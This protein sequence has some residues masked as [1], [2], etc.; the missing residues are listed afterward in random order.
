MQ[1]IADFV[2]SAINNYYIDSTITQNV[3]GCLGKEMK[4]DDWISIILSN[5]ECVVLKFNNGVFMNEGFV[6]N[7]EKVLK[8]F[9]NHQIGDIS[10]NEEQSTRVVEGIVDLDH[11][12]RFE[13]LVLKEGKIGIPFGYGEM[14]DDD[15]LLLYKGIMI[16]WKRFGYGTSYHDN[17]LIEYEGYWCDDNRFG[18]GKVYDRSGKL[19]KECLWVNGIESNID[20]KGDGLEP[21]NIGMKHL[22]LTDNCVLADWD[23]S[24]F[25]N[26][27][28]IEIGNDCFESVET[29]QIDGLNRLKTIKIGKNSFTQKKNSY[30]DD[31]SKS[32]HILNCESL[33]SIEIGE[34]SFSDF[35]G[36]FELKNLPQLQSIQIGTIG[37]NSYN[38]YCS[39]FVTRG[40]EL[41]LNIVMIISSKSTIHHVG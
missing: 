36:E 9:G 28:S 4:V 16:N 3:Q 14:Y 27:E 11:G 37:S 24:W 19:V 32:F 5:R 34:Y 21:L 40:I 39:S 33:E 22:K 12:S 31:K 26:L 1:S 30:G 10:Y 7:D 13:G 38:F 15:G 23:V 35:A 25:L 41:I 20:Y 8:V 17:G 6:V 29:F 18:S 2:N